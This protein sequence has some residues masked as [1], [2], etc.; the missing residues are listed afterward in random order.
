MSRRGGAAQ[1][2]PSSGPG[3]QPSGGADLSSSYTIVTPAPGTAAVSD[4]TFKDFYESLD[5]FLPTARPHHRPGA[6]PRRASADILPCPTAQVPDGLTEHAL[7]RC[8]FADPDQRLC[9]R[10]LLRRWRLTLTLSPS[11]NRVRLVSLAAQQL[12][13]DVAVDAHACVLV[14]PLSTRP[15]P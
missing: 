14:R 13:A 8:G 4:Q 3:A 11:P 6:L 15:V 5:E 2:G 12:V 7:L 10:R 9:V 1:A